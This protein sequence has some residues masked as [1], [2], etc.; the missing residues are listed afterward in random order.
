MSMGARS[1]KERRHLRIESIDET[2]L[3]GAGVVSQR[4][5]GCNDDLICIGP[6]HSDRLSDELRASAARKQSST[7]FRLNLS[8]KISFMSVHP[9]YLGQR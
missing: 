4:F 2:V 6:E 7:E 1:S 3:G 5:R 9:V 8:A